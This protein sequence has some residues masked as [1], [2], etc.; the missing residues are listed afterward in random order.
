MTHVQRS[1]P[2]CPRTTDVMQL[3][4]ESTPCTCRPAVFL[5]FLHS[6]HHSPRN[7]THPTAHRRPHLSRL[8]KQRSHTARHKLRRRCEVPCD[9]R[10][11][12]ACLREVLRRRQRLLREPTILSRR[13]RDTLLAVTGLG[14]QHHSLRL[15]LGGYRACRAWQIR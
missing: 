2:P 12:L 7:V 15:H 4:I 1:T 8:R 11:P 10:R 3:Y 9:S 13:C 14:L 6:P 5:S